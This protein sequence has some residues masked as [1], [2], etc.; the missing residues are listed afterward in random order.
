MVESNSLRY[1]GK[2][3]LMVSIVDLQIFSQRPGRNSGRT[4]EI[5][6]DIRHMAL[7]V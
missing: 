3:T 2:I 1:G 4:D 6:P 7:Q 5:S